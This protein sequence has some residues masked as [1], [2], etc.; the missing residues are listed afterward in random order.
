MIVTYNIIYIV[1]YNWQYL[2]V[3]KWLPVF[4]EGLVQGLTSYYQSTF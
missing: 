1:L 3:V 4:I 2:E